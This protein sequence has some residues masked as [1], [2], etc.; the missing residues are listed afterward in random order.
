MWVDEE[1]IDAAF[2]DI[3]DLADACRFNDCAHLSEPGCAVLAA[4]AA[5]ELAA[6][7]L[8]SYRKLL[9]EAAFAAQKN[10][11][12]LAREA[13]KVWKQRTLEGRGKAR[14]R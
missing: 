8:D 9:G 5:G 4:I 10:D 14:P 13:Q 11:T 12:R 1:G 7:R 3:T 6:D 2:N